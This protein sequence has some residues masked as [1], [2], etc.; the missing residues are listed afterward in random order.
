MG[1]L[2]SLVTAPLAPVRAVMWVAQRIA[3]KAEAEYYDPAPVWAALAELDGRLRRGEI[4]PA[5]FDRAE[6]ELLDRLDEI[7]RFRQGLP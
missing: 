4:D 3:D 5:D 7:A 2:T 1:L 6:E